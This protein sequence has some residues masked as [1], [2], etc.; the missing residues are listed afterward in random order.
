MTRPF[1][2][3]D[4][5]SLGEAAA[6]GRI[7]KALFGGDD[8][9]V[10]V[11]RYEVVESIG[12][13][14]FGKVYRARDPQLDRMVALKVL[15]VTHSGN[16]DVLREAKVMATI[17]H[18]NVVAIHDAGVVADATPPCVFLAMELIDGKHLRD[19]LATPRTQSE[20]LEVMRQAARG[21]R[22]AHA[23]G[24][25]HRDFKPENLLIGSDG[26][27]R[28]VDFGLARAATTQLAPDAD[29]NET[30][31]TTIA[32]TPAY[33]APEIFTGA[34]A[35][36]AT[37]QFAYC[38][39]L[40]EALY[41]ARPFVA[42]CV[43]QLT[44]AFGQPLA[45]PRRPRVPRNVARVLRR[46]L[47]TNAARRYS[48]MAELLLEL[49]PPH[50]VSRRRTIGAGIAAG[51]L[52]VALA[53]AITRELNSADAP[54]LCARPTSELAGVWD[55][56][57]RAT[58]A[59][60]FRATG[61]RHAQSVIERLT[62]GLDRATGDWIEA[63]REACIATHVRHEQSSELLDRRMAC[64]RDWRRQLA[65]LTSSFSRPTQPLV[66]HAVLA[67]AELPP[68]ARCANPLELVSAPPR[69]PATAA[70]LD[71][72]SDRLA[73]SRVRYFEGNWAEA[74]D[75][76]QGVEAEA[77]ALHDD[78][79]Q[80]AATVWQGQ[81]LIALGRRD[82]ARDVSRRCFDLALAIRDHRSAALAASA[83]AFHGA[84]DSSRANESL[85][86]IRTGEA[87]RQKLNSADDL[88]ATLAHI[89]GSIYVAV[90]EPEKARR[91]LERAVA[92]WRRLDPE[93]PNLATTLGML[94]VAELNL[95]S[96]EAAR[97][98]LTESVQ[99]CE[100]DLGPSHAE[101]G[102]ALV[103]L[104][105]AEAA[106]GRYRDAAAS[107]D[108]G[109][110][111]QIAALG[112]DNPTVGYAYLNLGQVAMAMGDHARADRAYGEAARI[113]LASYGANHAVTIVIEL[114][115]AEHA[116]RTGRSL[117][118]RD[119]ALRALG[120]LGPDDHAPRALAQSTLALAEH[121]LGRESTAVRT[122]HAALAALAA[123]HVATPSQRAIVHDNCGEVL[124]AVGRS[125]DAIAALRTADTMLD[126]G[127]PDPWRR[128][129]TRFA[130]ARA[131][132]D[133]SLAASLL[134]ALPSDI[135]PALRE[136]IAKFATS[137]AK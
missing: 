82:E 94:G 34:P 35:S 54:E 26:R 124:L 21:L 22:A 84:F 106:T 132:N 119:H 121:G 6:I 8:R 44:A 64:L 59:N 47:A 77:A 91:S 68:L 28:V 46:G 107:I 136:R 33:M 60:A 128:A 63:H 95:G 108:R 127:P 83:L 134:H 23:A 65:A 41:G 120:A 13:G 80:V 78:A 81:P 70:K 10:Q 71:E 56:I 93:H 52:G 58:I 40:W 15:T 122:T 69:D 85:T 7:E 51:A 72:L 112:A 12:A 27:V 32:G 16:D 29:L 76:A 88:V 89:E 55:P 102:N 135:D 38:I 98:H 1:A 131:T 18:P 87:L 101:L 24:I 92:A 43:E 57:Q 73:Q 42:R 3:S 20:L 75:I 117:I 113:A 90:A 99:R 100:R 133:R 37:D 30:S 61:L 53:V 39:T 103:N 129:Q 130:L 118:A 74:I 125:S 111:I 9:L 36:I 2:S 62:S 116:A 31:T 25:V 48:S 66:E 115:T 45:L 137:Q 126:H 110:A 14:G 104:A 50:G 4:A 17:G 96:V 109:M 79:T 5:V 49:E 67:V 11:G 86:W 105:L 19:W 97:Q 114:A 123:P